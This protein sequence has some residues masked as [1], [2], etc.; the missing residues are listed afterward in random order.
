M[1]SREKFLKI[2][3]PLLVLLAAFLLMQLLLQQRR[4]PEPRV[5]E[6]LGALVE[7]LTVQPRSH[8]VVVS[9][10]GTVQ[11]AQEIELLPRVSGQISRLGKNFVAGG[12]VRRGELL[13][14]IDPVDYQLALSRAQAA[15]AQAQVAVETTV[16]RAAIARLEWQQ[17]ARPGEEEPSPL[18]LFQPQL[19]EARAGLAAAEADL[20][21]A[22]LN[23]ERTEIRSPFN[24]RIR[25]KAAEVGQFVQAGSRIAVLTGTDAVEVV[26][27]VPQAELPWLALPRPGEGLAAKAVR[28]ADGASPDQLHRSNSSAT[29]WLEAGGHRYQWPGRLARTLGE[30]EPQGRMV[31]LVITIPDPYGLKKGAAPTFEVDLLPGMFVG[32]ELGGRRLDGV[33]SLPR[34]A[35]R[36][37]STVW[38]LGDDNRLEVRPVAVVRRERDFVLIDRGLAAGDRVVLTALAGAA[39]GLPLRLNTVNDASGQTGRAPF[40]SPSDREKPGELA[41]EVPAP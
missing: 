16:G 29:V 19:A 13:L 2:G 25:S 32:V 23:L 39:A 21:A 8:Q 7:V 22:K 12:F 4:P 5:K 28:T 17:F 27:P 40:A 33:F 30:V 26:A 11:A 15:V 20:A 36:E 31:Q 24:A 1:I 41:G 37:E 3:L 18:A 38:L 14:V 10:T 35:L 6:T 34:R 9:A